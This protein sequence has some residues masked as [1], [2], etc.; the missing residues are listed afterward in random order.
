MS[1]LFDTHSLQ[2][3]GPFRMLLS[4]TSEVVNRELRHRHIIFFPFE[5]WEISVELLGDIR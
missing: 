2:V 3:F 1:W 5:L 4:A